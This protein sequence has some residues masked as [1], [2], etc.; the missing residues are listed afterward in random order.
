MTYNIYGEIIKFVKNNN[1]FVISLLENV[2]NNDIMA[3]KLICEILSV[4]KILEVLLKNIKKAL[5]FIFI[6]D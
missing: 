2:K 3:L 4:S 1:D 5:F 6:I